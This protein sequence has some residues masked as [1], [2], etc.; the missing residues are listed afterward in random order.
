MVDE[1][2]KDITL[3]LSGI[4]SESVVDGV[5]FRMAIFTQGCKHNCKGCQNPQTHAL[6]GGEVT[7]LKFV[8]E[9]IEKDPLLDGVTLSGGE[10]FLQAKPLAELCR[11]VRARGLDVWCYSGYTY[12]ELCAL[13]EKDA[14]VRELLD[15]IDVLIDGR[16]VLEKL[17]LKL[18]F[19]G[20]SNQRILDMKKTRERGCPVWLEDME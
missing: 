12:E 19:R 5:G 16:F 7:D 17:D 15:G 20:S 1:K 14:D 8:L 11:Q 9:E 10:P 18:K 4:V 2:L 6:D 3:R 13:A